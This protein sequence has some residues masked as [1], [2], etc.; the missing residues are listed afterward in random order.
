MA[1]AVA[2]APDMI[3]EAAL[4][5]LAIVFGVVLGRWKSS[6]VALVLYAT[7]VTAA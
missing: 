2:L 6:A 3:C 4:M 7:I 5:G 1:V